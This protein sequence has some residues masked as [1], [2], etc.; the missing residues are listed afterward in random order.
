MIVNSDVRQ[1]AGY[2]FISPLMFL[3]PNLRFFKHAEKPSLLSF[4]VRVAGVACKTD[5]AVA[6][7]NIKIIQIQMIPSIQKRVHQL[8][9]HIVTKPIH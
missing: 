7:R 6:G 5:H 2:S 8:H 3:S 1:I 9:Q 4:T